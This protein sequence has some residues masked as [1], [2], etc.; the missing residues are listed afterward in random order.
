[1]SRYFPHGVFPVAPP[2]EVNLETPTETS[3]P[4]RKMVWAL[5][6]DIPGRLCAYASGGEAYISV[7]ESEDDALD[8]LRSDAWAVPTNGISTIEL[9]MESIVQQSLEQGASRFGHP[10]VGYVVQPKMEFARTD[11]N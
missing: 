4:E 3:L 1:M 11:G 6:S 9:S 5:E 8:V 7:F 2:V 10:I